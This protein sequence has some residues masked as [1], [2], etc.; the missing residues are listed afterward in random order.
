MKEYK[1][2]A[3]LTREMIQDLKNQPGFGIDVELEL[4]KML[5]HEIKMDNDP[6]YAAK[7]NAEK[8]R[9]LREKKIKRIFN[10]RNII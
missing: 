3:K 1:L 4:E 7:Y 10:A 6:Q 2:K 5:N 8:I 9:D